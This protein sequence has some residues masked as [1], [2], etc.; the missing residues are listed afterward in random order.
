MAGFAVE[1]IQTEELKKALCEKYDFSEELQIELLKYSEN[2][3]YQLK[4]G[5]KRYVLRIYRPGYHN[6]EELYGEILWQKRL[7]EDTCLHLAD[8]LEGKDGMLIQRAEIGRKSYDIAVF[9]FVP[10]KVLRDLSGEKLYCYMEKM[11]E[12]T[13]ILH[14]HAI[15]WKDAGKLK[16]FHW[17]F[18]DLAGKNARWGSFTEMKTLTPDQK[19]CYEEA[20]SVAEKRLQKY[21]KT[22]ERYGLI[23]GDLNINNILV[24]G[25]TLYILDFDDCGY[26]WFLYDLSTAVLEYF[27]ETM[28]RSLKALL[29]GYQKYRCL[30]KEDLEEMETFVVLR[31]IVR[32]G[33]IAT[34][35]DN[36]TV[37][38]VDPGYYME[39]EKMAEKY[40][41]K[42]GQL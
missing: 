18:E 27:G 39:T 14:K 34:H 35:L 29:Q 16:R 22:K 3:T 33:W 1:T 21:G 23:H 42:N 38:K 7:K 10:G 30:S 9:T 36:D 5:D 2:L 13:G 40:C 11:G 17:D 12:I 8:I 25:E 32:V 24:D 28:E 41:K 15:E 37:K 19:K 6:P 26:G 20:V 4:T 31:K